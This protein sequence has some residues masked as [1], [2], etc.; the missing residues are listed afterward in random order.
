MCAPAD[1]WQAGCDPLAAPWPLVP[2]SRPAPAPQQLPR[3]A[4]QAEPLSPGVGEPVAGIAKQ[5]TAGRASG[6]GLLAGSCWHPV[7]AAAEDD[8][9]GQARS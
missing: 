6:R 4:G 9:G 1:A 7:Q 8:A 3:A 2:P 5:G